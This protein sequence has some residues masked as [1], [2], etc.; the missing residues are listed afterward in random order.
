M[1][2]S[3]ASSDETA[4]QNHTVTIEGH[5]V[6]DDFAE[7][8]LQEEVPDEAASGP[9]E[10]DSEDSGA[11]TKPALAALVGL[12]ER[13]Q[14][15]RPEILRAVP[16]HQIVARL[17]RV[18]WARK[19]RCF[20]SLS[21]V[22]QDY[23]EFLSHSWQVAVWKKVLLLMVIKNGLPSVVVGTLTSLLMVLLWQ[24][25]FLPGFPKLGEKWSCWCSSVG[26][27]LALFSLAFW[28]PRGSIFVDR[29]C[30]NQFDPHMKT[31]G[32][33]NIG[34][35]LRV[36]KSL[37]VLFDD[38]YADRLWCLFEIA[39]F[40][41]AHPEAAE[42]PDIL[43]VKPILLG[44]IICTTCIGAFGAGFFAVF[45]PFEDRFLI[46]AVII[47]FVTAE[48]LFLVHAF[49]KY[50]RSLEAIK[51]QMQNFRLRQAE[52]WC[53]SVNHIH[54][55]SGQRI[56]VC[57]RE[58]VSQC[59]TSWFGSEQEFDE[60]VRSLAARALEQQLGYDAFPYLWMLG[61]FVPVWWPFMDFLAVYLQWEENQFLVPY[62]VIRFLAYW[63]FCLPL[64][65]TVGIFFA[66]CLRRRAQWMCTE[67][68]LDALVG[69]LTL[70]SFLAI[71]AWQL[72]TEITF[73]KE[74]VQDGLFETLGSVVFAAGCG[75]A[76]FAT[77]KGFHFANNRLFK[78]LL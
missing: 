57:D 38:S 73:Y 76:L 60:S 66:R 44:F 53:C 49:R 39:A 41:K 13:M 12:I 7:I 78:R 59:V 4:H 3:D 22:T 70:P 32:I 9:Q 75:V 69:V 77:R 63:L 52:C 37:L 35:V 2:M 72:Y 43:Q 34:A 11:P 61:S 74:G 16:T 48:G 17:G 15:T 45:S 36:S 14:P 8:D 23:D 54:P 51:S 40:L 18:F 67:L 33:I 62:F 47:A 58:I 50:Y 27:I 10:S 71:V 20:F 42:K 25:D 29:V 68:F 56:Q 1:S 24:L 64:V 26:L 5:H 55:A 21:K 46:W 28:R 6:P 31:E 19:D 65:A 30:I